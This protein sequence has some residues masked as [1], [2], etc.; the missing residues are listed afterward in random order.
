VHVGQQ[1]EEIRG[2]VEIRNAQTEHALEKQF[3]EELKKFEQQRQR[4]EDHRIR[5]DALMA[6][7]LQ[8]AEEQLNRAKGTDAQIIFETE[9]EAIRNFH[10]SHPLE[11]T[12]G[13]SRR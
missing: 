5:A 11:K 9:M 3:S 2:H 13:V 4:D 8:A 6:K 7:R 12:H 10:T 1:I